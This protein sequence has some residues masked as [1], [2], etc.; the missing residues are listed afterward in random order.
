MS[1]K[2]VDSQEQLE[3]L[4]N[5]YLGSL[6]NS[7]MYENSELETRF[8]TRGI[9]PITKI[10]FDNVI[11]KLKA[12]GFTFENANKYILRIQ[13]EHID[14]KTGQKRV[15]NIRTQIEGLTN[16]QNYCK[17]NTLPIDEESGTFHSWLSFEQKN[18]FKTN[19]EAVYPV[20]F[21]DFNFRV[22]LNTETSWDVDTPLIQ[23]IL[24]KW[25]ATKKVFRFINRSSLTHPDY[26]FRIDLSIVKDTHRQGRYTI[27][28]YT[29][30]ESKVFEAREKYE[31]EIEAIR[32]AVQGKQS[33][34]QEL[35]SILKRLTKYVLCGLQSTN[36]P[37]SY[38]EQQQVLDDYIRLVKDKDAR[39]GARITPKD[40]IGPSSYTLQTQ[41]ITTVNEDANIPNIRNNY[42]VTDKADGSR[43][44]LYVSTKGKIYLITTNM[45]VQFT[46]AKT[47][48]QK[49]IN[50][51]LDGEHILHDKNGAFINLY[52]SFDAYFINGKDIRSFGFVPTNVEEMQTKFRIPLL[53]EFIKSL[54]A[55]SIVD[56]R[57]SPIRITNKVFQIAHSGTDIFTACN[58][59]L[60]QVDEGLFEYE[61]DGLIFTPVNMGVGTDQI[62]APS[63]S[64]KITW[65]YSFKWKPPKYNTIDFLI[66]TKKTTSGVDAIG[67][68][69]QSGTDTT[70]LTQLTQYKTAIL[71]VGFD[72]RKH[73]YI[74]PCENIINDKLPSP[75]NLDNEDGY[76]PVPFFPTNP[77]DP[78]ASISKILLRESS[79]G[80]KSMYTEENELIE[81]NMIVEFSY[82]A[83][84]EP[85]WRWQPLR[86]RYDKT[87]EYRG[88]LK[89]YGNAYHVADSNWHSIH[90]PIT[91]NMLMTGEG[92]PDE[93][94][95][96]DIYYNKVSGDTHT[97]ALRD[98]HNLFVK[99]LLILS[100]SNR[101]DTLIDYA[102]GKGGDLPKWI[103][104]NLS[105][106]FGID[107]SR[108]NIENRLDGVCA[109]YLNYRKKFRSMP[110]GLFVYGNSSVNIKNTQALYSEKGKQI[111]RA[112]FGAGPKDERL[113]GT[114]VF[115][116][117]GVAVDGFNI[118]S[119][120]FA[121]H[122]MFESE[123]T[124]QNF[125]KN[126]S[127]CT[128]VDGYFIGTSLDGQ[129]LF[130]E[131]K[132]KK[133]GEAFTIMEGDTKIWEVKKQYDR[134]DFSA[135]NSSLG[136]GIDIF[137]ESINK[138]FRE[139]LVNYDYLIRLME[140]YGFKLLTR[141]EAIRINLPA[142]TGL[143]NELYGVLEQ[144]IQRNP[145]RRNE[146]GSALNM[147]AKE[148]RISFLNRYFVFKKIRNVDTETVY[149]SL[150]NKTEAEEVEEEKLSETAQE[151]VKESIVPKNKSKKRRK[152]LKLE[153]KPEEPNT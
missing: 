2:S 130:N 16:I 101:G 122:Y 23:G 119:I 93:L 99:K 27:P 39:S 106:V 89:N 63:K 52:A 18:H 136:Y 125:L 33:S 146:Y 84:R 11:Q 71:R 66:T 35:A 60:K 31:I 150:L 38:R 137:Q 121:I 96:D 72:E 128:K 64:F 56:N 132:N 10:D 67:T 112:V 78:D 41:N 85:G 25:S 20:N 111:T 17:T 129:L 49:L 45:Q 91:Q 50:S 61:T 113:L 148:R 74:N 53:I 28:E 59:I 117:Y 5:A 109:R 92:I 65:E 115:K 47:I 110:R 127:E 4:L 103:R 144:E 43:K 48:N 68:I 46:G 3:N 149:L 138:T 37:I 116:Q 135:D 19:R 126:I 90:N 34:A 142:G 120:Q 141:D 131:L 57:L 14:A 54:N 13:N 98:F 102:V 6:D 87:A 80:V 70:S 97:R 81:D 44:L 133:Q 22:A 36:Y 30:Q 12:Q 143:F 86:V 114:G 152:K 76:K 153:E 58:T 73:G 118:S 88:G 104:A 139:Y 145:R 108:D 24:S 40:F 62:G 1:S 79:S 9:K 8:G 95:D 105:F 107:I 26:P 100:T 69:F 140:N 123:T 55:I 51:L 21:D 29:V 7:K 77:Y 15:S 147:T 75:G 134:T 124:L 42:T 32:W 94:G 83:S 151:I 82:D